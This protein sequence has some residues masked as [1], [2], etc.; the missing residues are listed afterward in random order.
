VP[1]TSFTERVIAEL[2]PHVPPLRCCRGALIEGMRLTSARGAIETTRPVAAR[3]ALAAL[4]ADA[5]VAHVERRPAPRRHRLLVDAES[6]IAASEGL[7]CRRS[8]LRGALMAAGSVSRPDAP[9]H[10]EVLAGSIAAAQRL[11]GDLAALG[12]SASVA[13][14]RGAAVVAVRTAPGVADALSSVGAQ[15]GRLEF[16]EGRV[17]REVRSGVNRT[18]NAET[19]NLRRSVTAA[20]QQIEAIAALRDDRVRWDAL[21]PALR[22]AAML[23]LRAP[24]ATLDG[25]AVRAGCSRS[26]MAGRLRR[27]VAAGTTGGDEDEAAVGTVKAPSPPTR[28]RDG[29][30]GRHQRVRPDRAQRPARGAGEAR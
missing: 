19:G 16:E 18:L 3:A 8:R 6:T 29:R 13:E 23:R 17:V 30:Q 25:L 14:R 2:A 20:L 7:C 24:A 1:S 9:P 5:V 10:L 26:A 21:P 11:R 27:L 4:H 15:T 12:V 22:E 28:S